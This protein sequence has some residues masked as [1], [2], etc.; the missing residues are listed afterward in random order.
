MLD[1]DAS[2]LKNSALQLTKEQKESLRKKHNVVDKNKIAVISYTPASDCHSF[3]YILEI[4]AA[5]RG[6]CLFYLV[7][8]TKI[9]HIPF[10]YR[11][12]VFCVN[13][14]GILKDFYAIADVAINA[15]N[16][17]PRDITLHNFVEATEGGPLFMIKPKNT[18]Q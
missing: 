5:L 3:K 15:E 13:K 14:K 1:I 17:H 11:E 6:A 18:A 16:L 9:E 7:G 8:E 4:I 12:Q 2:L 10:D